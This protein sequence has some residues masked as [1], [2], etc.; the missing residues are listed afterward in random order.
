[1]RHDVP[2]REA[3]TIPF[4]KCNTDAALFQD[5]E[6]VSFGC[7]IRNSGGLFVGAKA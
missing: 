2:N 6:K 4:I 7:I 3:P 1:M 5:G